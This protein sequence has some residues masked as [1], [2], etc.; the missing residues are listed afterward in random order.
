MKKLFFI[1]IICAIC[2][3]N[4]GASKFTID[5]EKNAHLHN[6]LGINNL[7]E[8]YY[9]G[10]IKEFEMAIKLNPNTQATAVYYSNLGRTYETIGYPKMAIDCYERALIQNPVNLDYYI[11]LAHTYKKQGVLDSKLKYYKSKNDNPMNDIIIGFIYIE[12]GDISTGVTTL[13]NFCYKEPDIILTKG[14]KNY[15]K[16][17]VYLNK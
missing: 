11:K 7:K 15:L 6:N 1:P 17:K 16:N 10:A 14:I 8:K 9:L 12:K 5:A 2:F 4:L 13:D 3:L